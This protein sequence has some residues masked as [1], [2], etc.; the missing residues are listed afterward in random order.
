MEDAQITA[1]YWA[2]DEAA[3]A[4]SHAKYGRM[5]YGIAYHILSSHEDSEE[6]VSSTY[7]RLADHPASAPLFPGRLP[8]AHR[9]QPFHQPVAGGA[10]EKTGRGRR[11]AAF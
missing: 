10:G 11:A 4:E 9:P 2:R 6:T 8:G 3:I 5:L 7:P 1:L